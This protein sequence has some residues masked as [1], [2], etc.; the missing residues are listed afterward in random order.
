MESNICEI[1]DKEVSGS[2]DT[3]SECR[4]CESLVCNDCM[5]GRKC[6][7]CVK[8]EG[9]PDAPLRFNVKGY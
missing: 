5:M 9:G 8:D 2:W 1:C 6:V 3:L 7:D 4:Q